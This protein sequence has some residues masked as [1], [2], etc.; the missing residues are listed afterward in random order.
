VVSEC[1]RHHLRPRRRLPRLGFKGVFV[2]REALVAGINSESV[3]YAFELLGRVPAPYQVGGHE[4]SGVDHGVVRAVVPLVEDYGVES[5]PAGLHPDV[6]QDVVS[7]VVR[8]G[9]VVNEHLRDGLQGERSVVIAGSV[10]IALGADD[11]DAESV[12]LLG[13]KLWLVVPSSR[14]VVARDALFA[15]EQAPA[16]Q[17]L[18]TLGYVLTIGGGSHVI[19][20]PSAISYTG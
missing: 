12:A 18:Q 4:C 8:Q 16:V 19:S 15:Y 7:S 1:C 10:G 20:P 11:A 5:V 17:L 6:L 3:Q 2:Y 9:Q 13:G 14:Q